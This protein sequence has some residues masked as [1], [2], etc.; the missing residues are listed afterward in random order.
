[1][2]T[3]RPIPDTFFSS[4][5]FSREQWE[6]SS[7]GNTMLA[8]YARSQYA[9]SQTQTAPGKLVVMLYD[10]ELRFLHQALE[11]LRRR[12]LEAQGLYLGKAQRILCHLLGTLDMRAGELAHALSNLYRYCLER[13]VRA[14]AEDN[15]AYIEEVIRLLAPLR[16]AWDECERMVRS[17]QSEA[18]APVGAGR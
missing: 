18:A 17:G 2:L 15:A 1:M 11:A 14:N 5:T 9:E 3:Q 10:G 16:D 4:A 12:D 7:M 13:L 6:H 8:A